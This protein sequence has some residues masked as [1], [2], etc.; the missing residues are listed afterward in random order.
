MAR[1]KPTPAA[2]PEPEMARYV[3]LTER[4]IL[5]AVGEVITIAVGDP[6]AFSLVRAGHLEPVTTATPEEA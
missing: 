2:E 3:V 1:A 4:C 5:G 6:V